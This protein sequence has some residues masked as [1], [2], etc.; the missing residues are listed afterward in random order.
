MAE[1]ASLRRTGREGAI[2]VLDVDKFKP[3]N[4]VF[5]HAAGD[6][7]LCWVVSTLQSTVRQSDAIGR[8]GGD[9]FAIVLPEIAAEEVRA[10]STRIGEALAERAP[11]SFGV[12]LYPHD[13]EDLEALTRQADARLYGS[14]RGRY[15]RERAAAGAS[16][17]S[18]AMAAARAGAEASGERDGGGFGAIDL[19][20]AALD[21]MPSRAGRERERRG[22]PAVDAARPDRRVRD[23]DRHDR[24]RDQLEPR[25][26][27][28]LRL[29]RRGGDRPQRP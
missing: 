28:A 26:G 14:R 3:V 19:W 17:D 27:G 13:G 21:A 24:G 6:E 8:L 22:H 15:Q 4:D 16:E 1:L 9:E 2:L 23:R 10:L 18:A 12:A 5:G 25:R 7:L 11:C 29:E 20:R